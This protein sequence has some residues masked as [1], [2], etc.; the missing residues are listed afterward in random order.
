MANLAELV[1]SDPN[2]TATVDLATLRIALN[3][4][5]P[6]SGLFITYSAF[7]SPEDTL[8]VLLDS[9]HLLPGMAQVVNPVSAFIGETAVSV[10]FAGLVRGQ[11]G[12]YQVN[13][14]V[15]ASLQATPNAQLTLKQNLV[16]LGSATSIDIFSNTVEFPVGQ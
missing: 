2:V 10:T 14:T 16:V 5:D 8:E 15:P 4:R 9:Q 11:V 13:F 1:N 6:N 12:L 3:L 7:V